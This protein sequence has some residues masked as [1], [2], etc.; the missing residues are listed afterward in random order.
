MG[1]PIAPLLADVFM[2]YV[3]DKALALLLEQDKPTRLFCYVDDLFLTFPNECAA[4]RFL[5]TLN[6]IHSSI[7]FTPKNPTPNLPFSMFC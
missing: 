3:L 7:K 5:D 4:Q 1:L 6:L 2:N